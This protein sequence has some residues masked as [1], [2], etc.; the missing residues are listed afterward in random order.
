ME[1]DA[2]RVVADE[3][4]TVEDG[5]GIVHLA[6]AF[7]E[8]DREVAEREGLPT[9]N[10][11]ND[12][13]RFTADVGAPYAG[14]FV[15][16]ADPALVD[17]LAA[18]GKLVKLVDYTHSY[19][20]CWRCDTPLI[21]WAKPTWFARTSAAKDALLR[22][23]QKINWHPEHIKDGRF[24][25]WLANNVDWALSRDRYWGTPIPVWRCGDCGHDTCVGSVA[26]LSDL[27]A[28]DLTGMDLHRP[29]VDDVT[30]SCPACERG[31]ATRVAPVLDAWFD[32]GSMPT[33]QFHYPF[34]NAETF[35][36]HFPADFICEAID[37]TR[38]VLLAA[39][40]EHARVR[41]DAVP[42]RRVPGAHR[43]P[44]RR[45]DVEV[46][47]QRDRPV[48]GAARARRRGVALVHVLL[49]IAV[50]AQARAPSTGSTSR[51]ASSS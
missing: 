21:Y 33:A 50:D 27:S 11:V 43:R 14:K 9:V 39:R 25:D 49:G 29:Y 28:R 34:E 30:I 48:V 10:P 32:S 22:E 15:K 1:G 31:T 47:R 24:G 46:A 7:G 5:S 12:A 16:D 4:V 19:P 17:A 35:E 44:G 6:P 41:P 26:E 13:A 38:L 2:F 36:K 37:Q 3:F 51:P 42:E 18:A 23:N 20:H 8:I 40:G 45:E